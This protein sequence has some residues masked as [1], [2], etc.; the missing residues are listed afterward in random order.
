MTNAKKQILSKLLKSQA[1]AWFFSL[2]VVVAALATPDDNPCTPE[3]GPWKKESGSVPSTM[4]GTPS[5]GSGPEGVHH[6]VTISVMAPTFTFTR[7]KIN[8]CENGEEIETKSVQAVI[9]SAAAPAFS[10]TATTLDLRAQ[11]HWYV[12]DPDGK[13]FEGDQ[14]VLKA[15]FQITNVPNPPNPDESNN[16]GN[17]NP[18]PN[19]PNPCDGWTA[20]NFNHVTWTDEDTGAVWTSKEHFTGYPP[21]PIET[22]TPGLHVVNDQAWISTHRE[23]YWGFQQPP[24][25]GGEINVYKKYHGHT[26]RTVRRYKPGSGTWV[27]C[28]TYAIDTESEYNTEQETFTYSGDGYPFWYGG[29]TTNS[30]TQQSFS[31]PYVNTTYTLSNP[32]TV[33]AFQGRFDSKNTSDLY[34]G[35]YW[36]YWPSG[37]YYLDEGKTSLYYSKS[38]FKFKWGEGTLQEEKFK[39][40]YVVIYYPEDDPDTEDIDESFENAEVVD[41][42]TWEGW[43]TEAES[44]PIEIDPMAEGYKG[45]EN[46]YYAL[47][48]MELESKDRVLRGSIEIPEGWKDVS[49][50][51][52]NKDSDEDLGIFEKLEPEAEQTS[53]KIYDSPDDFFNDQE[54]Q[55]NESDSLPDNV[56]NQKVTFARDPLNPRKLEFCAVFDDIG[57]IE[58]KLKFGSTESEK[59][60][61]HT[62]TADNEV[63]GFLNQMD[64]RVTSIEVPGSDSLPIDP[65]G[66]GFPGGSDPEDLI[67]ARQPG[68]MTNPGAILSEEHEDNP[69]NL[70]VRLND[71]DDDGGTPPDNGDTVISAADND[72]AMLMLKR[73]GNLSANIGTLTLTVSQPNAVRIFKSGGAAVLGDYTVNLA[74][75]SGDLAGLA[76]GSVPIFVEGLVETGD[77]TFTLNYRNAQNE[78]VAS[79]AIHLSVAGSSQFAL[80]NMLGGFYLA[81]DGPVKVRTYAENGAMRMS[82]LN[83]APISGNPPLQNRSMLSKIFWDATRNNLQIAWIKGFVDGFW[84]ALKGEK[85]AVVG[86]W[87]FF[88]DDPFGRG[89]A[90]CGVVKEAIGQLADVPPG[91]IPSI[92]G[93]ISRTL[94]RDLYTQ[95][96][97]NLPWAPLTPNLSP[98]VLKYMEGFV[99]GTITEGVAVSLMGVG[100]ATKAATVVKGVLAT[101]RTGQYALTMFNNLRRATTK[102]MHLLLTLENSKA[103]SVNIGAIAQRLK[104][105]QLPGGKRATEGFSDAL[106]DK[107]Q[108]AKN[109]LQNYKDA[110]PDVVDT[111]RRATRY[112]KCA[113]S[114]ADLQQTMGSTLTDQGKE[115]FSKLQQ[116]LFVKNSDSADCFPELKD[117]FNTSTGTGKTELNKF[118]EDSKSILDDPASN[119]PSGSFPNNRGFAGT[120]VSKTY[121]QNTI[122]TRY[123]DETG[124]FLAEGEPPFW[125]RSLPDSQ[126]STVYK[127]YRVVT[128]FQANSGRAAPWFGKPGGCKQVDLGEGVTVGQLRTQ[129]YLE[130]IIE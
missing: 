62:L 117:M 57:V 101:A 44:E 43:E 28:G 103:G 93:E 110:W 82:V 102:T 96:E 49:L 126:A 5:P 116:R 6:T 20:P 89:A 61:E 120:P 111:T 22:D 41:T 64:Q 97:Q 88:R 15:T 92:L 35:I 4:D 51:F 118:L 98:D 48:Q 25:D 114:M 2:M 33:A 47:H 107:P 16:T 42:I 56:K 81:D 31:S 1:L 12:N 69:L 123:G 55:Q 19:E 39:P 53:V 37:Q 74:S 8:D 72:V 66:G 58:V 68:T 87:T 9:A 83:L 106:H 54:M 80:L 94:W 130:E 124:S 11:T 63:A 65:G 36:S 86:V 27:T 46:G 90:M 104:Q 40:V 38:K 84:V 119:V 127:K 71:D 73:P 100:V 34:S 3:Y 7:E 121:S 109:V 23:G 70:I 125:T 77:V 95:A 128:P 13:R 129:G 24:A 10:S 26:E 91:E 52:K 60:V 45:K 108:L 59:A 67:Q 122:L 18:P 17:P 105:I 78:V 79:D 75:P 21:E 14:I 113:H 112:Q 99:A 76:A 85:D 30:D 29:L 32:H 115:S 50:S